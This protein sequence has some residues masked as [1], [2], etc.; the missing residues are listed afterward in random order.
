MDEL[1]N[2]FKQFTNDQNKRKAKS[3]AKQRTAD[4]QK[5]KQS[6]NER[7]AKS[8]AKEREADNQKVK[9]GQNERNAKFIAKQRDADYQKVKEDQN[10]RKRLSRNKRKLDFQ[11]TRLKLKRRRGGYG[12]QK[13]D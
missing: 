1:S 4:N 3:N 5:V 6:Q 10:K 2:S 8:I 7:K 13:I 11:N 12:G 9:Q